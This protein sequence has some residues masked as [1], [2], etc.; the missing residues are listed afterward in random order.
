MLRDFKVQPFQRR[1]SLLSTDSSAWAVFSK[2]SDVQI[3]GPPVE[4]GAE[5]RGFARGLWDWWASL[6][7]DARMRFE[8]AVPEHKKPNGTAKITESK[9]GGNKG[10][11]R[12]KKEEIE[13]LGVDLPGSQNKRRESMKDRS[14]GLDG[15][16]E[17][18]IVHESVEAPKRVLRARGAKGAN[19]RSESARESRF[20]TVFTGGL[21]EPDETQ[22][23]AH[24]LRD[25]KAYRDKRR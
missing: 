10:D 15:V 4:F 20:G 17:G 3:R 21:G 7:D 14:L 16:A 24:E 1:P 8:N 6:G 18:D 9:A 23:S 12:I 5:E 25:G 22:G 19:G 13:G 11:V 2:G